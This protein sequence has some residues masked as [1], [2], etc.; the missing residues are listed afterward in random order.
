MMGDS[1][2]VSPSLSWEPPQS[3]LG[4]GMPGPVR[5]MEAT[6]HAIQ[7]TLLAISHDSKLLAGLEKEPQSWKP[8]PAS[9]FVLW[10]VLRETNSER[11]HSTKIATSLLPGVPERTSSLESCLGE[12]VVSKISDKYPHLTLFSPDTKSIVLGGHL[13]SITFVNTSTGEEG[14]R[15]ALVE[16]AGVMN[17]A[18]YSPRWKAIRLAKVSNAKFKC[19]CR[20]RNDPQRI[21]SP[22]GVGSCLAF[23]SGWQNTSVTDGGDGTAALVWDLSRIPPKFR[24]PGSIR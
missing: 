8:K 7:P 16:L 22:S 2:S 14:A 20:N 19:R 1:C 18:A 4:A 12:L 17:G 10:R 21:A 23:S 5:S 6:D 15:S 13:G 9:S 11:C 3:T 24:R